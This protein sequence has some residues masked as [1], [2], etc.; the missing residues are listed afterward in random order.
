[1][2]NLRGWFVDGMTEAGKAIQKE[3]LTKAE[4]LSMAESMVEHWPRVYIGQ[5]SAKYPHGAILGGIQYGR[6]SGVAEI[7]E[8]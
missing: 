1:M 6:R 5:K 8:S 4:A 7:P 2:R 3:G